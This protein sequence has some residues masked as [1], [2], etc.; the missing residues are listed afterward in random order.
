MRKMK[1]IIMT[2]QGLDNNFMD[3]LIASKLLPVL[4]VTTSPF[5]C[6]NLNL[7]AGPGISADSGVSVLNRKYSKACQFHFLFFL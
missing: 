5:Y 1:F 3:E 4:I 6:G 7:L 2:D